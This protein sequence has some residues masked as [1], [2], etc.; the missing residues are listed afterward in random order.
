MIMDPR[1]IRDKILTLLRSNFDSTEL[2][3]IDSAIEEVI[4]SLSITEQETSLITTNSC[5]PDVLNYLVRKKAKGLTEATLE[6]YSLTLK[7][8]CIGVPKALP[9]ITE[10]DILNFLDDYERRRNIS[11]RR[12]DTMRVILNGFFRYMAD[13]GRI[14]SNPMATIEPIKYQKNVRQPLTDMELEKLRY[15][16]TKKKERALL[17]FF[18]ATGCRVSEAVNVNISDIDF[19][20]GSLK[21]IGKGNKERLVLLNAAAVMAIQTYL[22][23]R[24]DNEDALWISD[25]R[26]YH[27][28][29]KEA[30][31]K[32]IRKLGEKA[33]LGRRVYPHLLRHTTATFLL[34]HGMP[35][36]QVQDYL[37]HENINTTRIYAKTDV[38]AM[39][40]SYRGIFG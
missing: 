32:I 24:E 30:L 27:R 8:F 23:T 12:K 25:R 10:W 29:K 40:A 38:S 26:P 11:K 31:E 39:I 15:A 16:C 4:G 6:Q 2:T 37:G 1:E 36:E 13:C 22:D 20:N 34:R 18:F 3:M 33:E 17:E 19:A 35:L 14:R 9:D 5:M 7:A 21:V 28:I